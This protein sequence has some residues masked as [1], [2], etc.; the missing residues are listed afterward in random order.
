MVSK[1]SAQHKSKNWI[2]EAVFDG[3]NID[4]DLYLSVL[5]ES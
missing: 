2:T 3:I 4:I 5:A 1:F